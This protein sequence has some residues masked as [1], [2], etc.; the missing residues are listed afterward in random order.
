MS[1]SII[2]TGVVCTFYTT[3]VSI[4]KNWSIFLFLSVLSECNKKYRE[5][6]SRLHT[7]FSRVLAAICTSALY[8]NNSK[9][10][11]YEGN[12]TTFALHEAI[13]SSFL[14]VPA[15]VYNSLFHQNCDE[16]KQY[17]SYLA[18][19]QHNVTMASILVASCV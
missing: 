6:N 14:S 7:G 19:H 12:M 15:T 13:S 4:K 1:A 18:T 10:Q 3:L 8:K 11:E 2:S 9:R 17:D 16:Y 5:Q